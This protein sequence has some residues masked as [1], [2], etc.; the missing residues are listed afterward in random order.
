MEALRD[1]AHPLRVRFGGF[2]GGCETF[3]AAAFGITPPEAQL[4]D[5]QQRLLMEARALARPVHRSSRPSSRRVAHD[6]YL[7]TQPHLRVLRAGMC[8]GS[9]FR[10]L[11][12]PLQ[13]AAPT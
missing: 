1:G 2:V 3:D 11:L 10:G 6:S 9:N 4:M 8:C 13:M 12:L 5:P 7:R